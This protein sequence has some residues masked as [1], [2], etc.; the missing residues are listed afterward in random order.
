MGSLLKGKNF[1]PVSICNAFKN[2]CF[3]LPYG[4]SATVPLKLAEVAIVRIES[5]AL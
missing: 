3:D 4:A 5:T 2:G 1:N